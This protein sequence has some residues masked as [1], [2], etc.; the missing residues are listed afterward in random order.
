M[1]N[2]IKKFTDAIFAESDADMTSISI[3]GSKNALTR[4]SNNEITQNVESSGFPFTI[5]LVYKG[6][7]GIVEGASMDI[8]KIP[9]YIKKGKEIALNQRKKD[10]HLPLYS[11]SKYKSINNYNK[12]TEKID[13]LKRAKEIKKSIKLCEKKK[14]SA[15]GILSNGYNVFAIANSKGLFAFHKS[16]TAEHSISVYTKN[17]SGWAEQTET[18]F[19]NINV[20][21]NTEIAIEK[22][23]KAKNPK[24]IKPGK[25][26][27]VLEPAAVADLISF[28]GYSVFNTRAY[29]EKRSY[30]CGKMGKQIVNKN[31]S[32]MDNAYISNSGIPFD[33]EGFPRKTV[34]LIKNGKFVGL[35]HDRKSAKIL[36]AKNT[37]HSLGANDTYGP[38][39]LNLYLK[40][41]NSNLKEMIKSTKKGILVT[42]FH[43]VNILNPI[44]TIITGMT[45]NGIYLIENGKVTTGL[46]NFRFTQ[47]IIEALK[48][49]ELIGNTCEMHSGGFW[50]GFYVPA[51]KINNFNF[52]SVTDF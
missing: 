29:I 6:K 42:Q 51:L 43:Y 18:N 47:S 27:V 40:P 34:D 49:V 26:T 15:A 8:K 2:K 21:K 48:N 7:T 9:E 25:Y 22:A 36:K 10:N 50:G 14:L 37:G 12:S 19:S 1:K 11:G 13:P 35:V 44:E 28:M 17:S 23:L 45:R 33:F 41:G 52:S 31:I 4:F 32:I 20:K 38:I 3:R 39:P 5:M 46:K 30:L 24:T 16:T